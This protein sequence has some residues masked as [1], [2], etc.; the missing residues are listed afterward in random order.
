LTTTTTKKGDFFYSDLGV[1][2]LSELK[3]WNSDDKFHTASK[4]FGQ[5]YVIQGWFNQRQKTVQYKNSTKSVSIENLNVTPSFDHLPMASSES[6]KNASD[7]NCQ[8]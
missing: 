7:A 5:L 2:I 3:L 1:S 6:N 8:Y 4:Y